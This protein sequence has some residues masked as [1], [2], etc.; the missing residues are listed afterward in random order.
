MTYIVAK[1]A[2][3]AIRFFLSHVASTSA[4]EPDVSSVEYIYSVLIDED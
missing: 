1:S 4:V 3:E 2:D